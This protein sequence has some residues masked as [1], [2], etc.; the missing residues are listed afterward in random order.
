MADQNPLGIRKLPP[1][2]KRGWGMLL[3]LL[4]FAGILRGWKLSDPEHLLGDELFYVAASWTYVTDAHDLNEEHPPLGKILIAA[5]IRLGQA[6]GSVDKGQLPSYGYIRLPSFLGGLGIVF[7]TFALAYRVSQGSLETAELAAFFVASDFMSIVLSRL[8]MLDCTL[9]LWWLIGAYLGWLCLESIQNKGRYSW[10]LAALSAVA[11]S[12]AFATKWNGFVGGLVVYLFIVALSADKGEEGKIDYKKQA[13][14]AVLLFC[15]FCVIFSF[16]YMMSY[17]PQLFR[18]GFTADTVFRILHYPVRTWSEGSDWVNSLSSPF[19]AWPIGLYPYLASIS[20]NPDGSGCYLIYCGSIIFW[21]PGFYWVLKKF[22]TSW[23]PRNLANLFITSMWL[24]N[25]LF[26]I[27]VRSN[28]YIYYV[29]PGIP[30]MAIIMADVIKDLYIQKSYKLLCTYLF[31]ISVSLSL[32]YPILTYIPISKSM[33]NFLIPDW[34][35]NLLAF[36]K[37]MIL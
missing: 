16:F 4:L 18:E 34:V 19:W 7:F 24:G 17:L 10:G 14:K 23:R 1:W 20:V 31:A 37:V 28:G 32:Y 35:S 36:I 26:W 8:A 15:L 27:P 33:F 5:G 21:W 12:L 2:G 29:L 9:S 3:I 13:K 6:C 30:F 11:F 25:W 22:F